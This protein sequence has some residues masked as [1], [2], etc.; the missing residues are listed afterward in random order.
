MPAKYFFM[1]Q[2]APLPSWNQRVSITCRAARLQSI[3]NLFLLWVET[4]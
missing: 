3:L 4:F 1:V 2:I